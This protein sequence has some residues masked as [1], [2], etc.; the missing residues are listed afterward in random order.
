[1]TKFSRYLFLWSISSNNLN[2]YILL[3]L[4]RDVLRVSSNHVLK[5]T[6]MEINPTS[7][8]KISLKCKES[9]KRIP[10]VSS[11]EFKVSKVFINNSSYLVRDIIRVLS[12]VHRSPCSRDGNTLNIRTPLSLFVHLFIYSRLTLF[13]HFLCLTTRSFITSLTF[14]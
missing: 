8:Q 7:L 2:T 14:L 10:T 11:I 9:M 5:N 1:M 13:R 3:S 6:K 4:D 12:V